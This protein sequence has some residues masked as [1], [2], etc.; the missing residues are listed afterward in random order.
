MARFGFQTFPDR[1]RD[2]PDRK[3]EATMRLEC[4][5]I[6]RER[7]RRSRDPRS[8]TGRRAGLPAHAPVLE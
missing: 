7:E 5:R 3:C 6:F 8:F 4:A 1:A 2:V